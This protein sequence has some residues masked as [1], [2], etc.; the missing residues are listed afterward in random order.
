[1]SFF[2]QNLMFKCNLPLHT[3]ISLY[4]GLRGV[5]WIIFQRG[6]NVLLHRTVLGVHVMMRS[7]QLVGRH[8]RLLTH[9]HVD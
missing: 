8:N 4:T 7:L 6:Q 5:W 1:M 9:I 2:Y 3:V